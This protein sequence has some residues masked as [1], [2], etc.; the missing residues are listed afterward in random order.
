MNGHMHQVQGN[1][2]MRVF[3]VEDSSAVRELIVENC[4]NIPGIRWAGFAD[5]EAD[6]LSQLET[7]S[8]DVL[9]VDIELRQG[10]GMSLLRKL[11]ERRCHEDDLKIVFSN[12]ICD[13]YQRMGAR[14]GI[15]HFLDKSFQIGDLCAL[16]QHSAQRCCIPDQ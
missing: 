7:Q 4:A 9:I 1:G 16:L 12:N 13:A 11:A 6:A 15:Q 5:S 10:N 3:L 8:C 14:Y 2:A